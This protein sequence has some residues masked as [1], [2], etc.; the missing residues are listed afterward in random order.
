MLLAPSPPRP[1]P[2]AHNL[3]LRQHQRLVAVRDPHPQPELPPHPGDGG[4]DD[5]ERVHVV[6]GIEL[7]TRKLAIDRVVD[8]RVD[9]VR[10]LHGRVHRPRQ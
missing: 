5:P 3:R 10:A 8:V 1:L 6:D 2:H 4:A 7:R 9:N